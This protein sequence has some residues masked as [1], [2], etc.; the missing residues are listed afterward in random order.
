MAALES[1][2]LPTGSFYIF[3]IVSNATMDTFARKN[4]RTLLN[5]FLYIIFVEGETARSQSLEI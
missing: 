3:A 4:L 2:H 5:V 1:N